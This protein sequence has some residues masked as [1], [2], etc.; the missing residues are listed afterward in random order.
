MDL[1]SSLSNNSLLGSSFCGSFT[2]FLFD[3]TFKKKNNALNSV[4]FLLVC[5]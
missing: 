3:G 1:H 4:S 5:I 2:N